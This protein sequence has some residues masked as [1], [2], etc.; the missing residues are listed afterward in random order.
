M[1]LTR[2]AVLAGIASLAVA[3]AALAAEAPRF[4]TMTVNLPDGAV[5]HVRYTGDVAPTVTVDP[6][7]APRWFDPAGA[8]GDFAGFDPAPFA[9]LDRIASEMDRRAEAMLRQARFGARDATGGSGWPGLDLL[10]GGDLPAGAAGYSF[11]SQTTSNGRCTR[12]VEVTRAAPNAKPDVVT[13]ESGNCQ[14]SSATP[15][16]AAPQA[17][18]PGPTAAVKP[19]K[20]AAP[21][22]LGS[23]TA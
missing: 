20:P 8:F 9:A 14:G 17:P 11:V 2:K 22:A 10:A 7:P 16:P 15:A 21:P 5:A 19:A 6:A 18:P 13:H 1:R 3:G 12:S 23:G 4:H